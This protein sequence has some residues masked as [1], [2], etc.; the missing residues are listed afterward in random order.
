M[1]KILIISTG[2]TFNKVYNP[3]TGNLDIDKTSHA[4]KTLASKWLCDFEILNIIGKDS[5]EM[6]N[7]DRL[8][9]LSTIHQSSYHNI[10]IVHGTDTMDV[11]AQYLADAEL[12]KSIV[13]TG[14][15]VPYSIDA[16]EA[17]ANLASA[18]GYLSALEK[19]GV[20]IVMNGVF[21][22]YEKVNKNRSEGRFIFTS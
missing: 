19:R 9:L 13:L 14:A 12:E 5:L 6:T 15:M 1:K 18:Y 21:G 20:F 11:T 4:L 17:T 8:E 22:S 16:T 2:G 3:K 7:H 10:I